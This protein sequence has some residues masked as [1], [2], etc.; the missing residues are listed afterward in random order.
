MAMFRTPRG[1]SLSID[2]L[3]R[4]TFLNANWGFVMHDDY[5]YECRL[6]FFRAL[7]RFRMAKSLAGFKAWYM[8]TVLN[9]RRAE[10]KTQLK[11][12]KGRMDMERSTEW[13]RERA[14]ELKKMC[15][16][17]PASMSAPRSFGD[18]TDSEGDGEEER[19]E[20]EG[21]QGCPMK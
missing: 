1:S 20:K 9:K 15:L 3:R 6:E 4:F 8:K 17:I 7:R 12:E 14:K 18:E 13:D 5:F 10:R 19:L 21:E 2:N 16:A 11:M